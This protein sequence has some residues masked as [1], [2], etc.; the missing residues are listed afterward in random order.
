MATTP[1]AGT[2]EG[3]IRGKIIEADISIS[4]DAIHPLPLACGLYAIEDTGGVWLCAYYGSNRSNF[5]FLPQKDAEVEESRL[6]I[7]FQSRQF[8]PR[9]RYRPEAWEEFKKTHLR[10]L[11]SH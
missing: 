2:P 6:G 5:D 1:E 10:S 4:Q 9:D 7:T 8:V 3:P 11:A